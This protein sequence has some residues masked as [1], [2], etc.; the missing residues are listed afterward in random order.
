MIKPA[1]RPLLA[2]AIASMLGAPCAH[3]TN[4]YFAH[5]YSTKEKGLAGAGTAFSQD[6][7]AAATN[8]AGMVFVGDRLDL[9]AALFSPSPRSYTVTGSPP[10]PGNGTF[11]VLDAAGVCQTPHPSGNGAC[12][13]PFSVNPGKV[14]SSQDFFLIPHVGY[15]RMLDANSSVGVSV[16][17]NGGMNTQY[18]SGSA[19]LPNGNAPGLPVSTL[20]GPFGAGTAGV[21]LE[22]LFI[23]VSFA[24]KLN[25]N[26]AVGAGVIIAGQ[27]FAASGLDNFGQFSTDP[28][29][30]SGNRHA[31]SYGMGLKVGYQG[32]IGDGV[33]LGV[34]YQSRMNM[35]D[36][37]EYRG[38]FAEGGGFDIPSTYNVGVSFEIGQNAVFVAD[39][40]RINYT[41]VKS[42]SNPVSRLTDGSCLDA[43]NSSLS[44]GAAAAAGAGC[45]GGVNGAGFGWEDMTILKLGYQFDIGDNTYRLGFSHASQPIAGS[46]TLFN[47]LAPAVMENHFTA[48]MTLR[49]GGNQE[50]NIAAMYAPSRSVKGANPFDGGAT[51]IEIEM[52]QWEVQAG[53]AWRY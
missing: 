20:S 23:N 42:I 43:L 3:A 16:Y 10:I 5:G 44:G 41:D 39:L 38:L 15:N 33:R 4:G 2:F 18:E 45:L 24:K 51:Q 1:R 26:H 49:L 8:P 31:T 46:Q 40:Q 32:Q 27:R 17:G 11:N 21:N 25:R 53:W 14:E 6:A 52:R 47:I 37:D 30:L 19:T 29:N 9:G 7:M 35:G 34:S 28:A 12:A 22:Q 36:F 50:L 48:G 13:P